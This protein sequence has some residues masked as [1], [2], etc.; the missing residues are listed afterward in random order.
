MLADHPNFVKILLRFFDKTTP[1]L[2]SKAQKH[3][4]NVL[5]NRFCKEIGVFEVSGAW[6]QAKDKNFAL[7]C[8]PIWF[9]RS[10]G[11]KRDRTFFTFHASFKNQKP[12][13]AEAARGG[14]NFLG[15]PSSG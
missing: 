2:A 3:V 10:L 1:F 12:W 8:W 15:L 14:A 9:G 5:L 13:M 7:F 11:V 4:Q 6:I